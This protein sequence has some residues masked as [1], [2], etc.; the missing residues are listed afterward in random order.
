MGPGTRQRHAIEFENLL[1]EG[2]RCSYKTE[3]SSGQSRSLLLAVP[4]SLPTAVAGRP[5]PCP[6]TY[7]CTVIG[8][9]L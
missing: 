2:Y 8:I 1:V 3:I 9:A 5:S 7:A 6:G 4:V